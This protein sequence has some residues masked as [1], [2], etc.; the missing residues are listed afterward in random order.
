MHHTQVWSSW[1]NIGISWL[2][3]GVSMSK[4]NCEVNQPAHT[5]LAYARAREAPT[6]ESDPD[7]TPVET[8]IVI[9][10]S[11]ESSTWTE[12]ATTTTNVPVS[13]TVAP[14]PDP[15]EATKRVQSLLDRIRDKKP[16]IDDFNEDPTEEKAD[17]ILNFFNKEK[18][19]IDDILPT[20][21]SEGSDDKGDCRGGDPLSQ[22]FKTVKCQSD[23]IEETMPKIEEGKT[24]QFEDI[25]N[26]KPVLTDII[27]SS[28]TQSSDDNKNNDNNED[29]NNEDNNSEDNNQDDNNQDDNNQEDNNQEDNNQEDNN[30]EDNNQED[31]NQEDNNQ[32]DN[33]Q[34]D[35]NQE[36]NNQE[37]NNQENNN[38]EDN[39]QDDN[40]EDNNNEDD[41]KNNENTSSKKSSSSDINTSTSSDCE[42]STTENLYVECFTTPA[43]GRRRQAASDCSTSTETTSG[44]NISPITTTSGCTDVATVSSCDV[45]CPS[46]TTV[47]PTTGPDIAA[48]SETQST[49]SCSTTCSTQKA[50]STEDMAPATTATTTDVKTTTAEDSCATYDIATVT[51]GGD[52][53]EEPSDEPNSVVEELERIDAGETPTASQTLTGESE[54]SESTP[55]PTSSED[56]D[57]DDEDDSSTP[58]PTS[59]MIFILNYRPGDDHDSRWTVFA[60]EMDDEDPDWCST[61]SDAYQGYFRIEETLDRYTDDVPFPNGDGVKFENYGMDGL[62]KIPCVYSGT[63]DDPGQLTCLGYAE[64]QCSSDFDWFDERTKCGDDDDDY[65]DMVPRVR[66]AWGP[67]ARRPG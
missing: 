20:L 22:L 12:D 1:A 7:A 55:S 51:P 42:T 56:D 39:N 54:S 5:W 9:T 47:T 13:S 41:N 28:D 32:E 45:I 25:E 60:P 2:V 31:N 16:D 61:D 21:N 57:D 35:N 65:S 18:P 11:D 59:Q 6:P 64:V 66:C 15:P 24:N 19:E 67:E 8:V 34:D 53:P 17:N 10:K 58:T 43:P 52:G 4:V 40:N 23:K 46:T 63:W 48:R 50:C 38:Q 37:D 30:Q 62:E 44:C 3:F 26:I 27:E 36:D 49:E 33:N 29:N 14:G